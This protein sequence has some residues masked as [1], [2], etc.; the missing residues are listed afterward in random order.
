MVNVIDKNGG[1]LNPCTEAK[2]RHLLN[3]KK[4]EIVERVPF[5]I[6]LNFAVNNSIVTPDPEMTAPASGNEK[7]Q[8]TESAETVETVVF[9]G[10]T[11]TVPKFFKGDPEGFLYQ[12]RNIRKHY[13]GRKAS[14]RPAK[15]L[16]EGA[17]SHFWSRFIRGMKFRVGKTVELGRIPEKGEI[18]NKYGELYSNYPWNE[19]CAGKPLKW[20]VLDVNRRDKTVLLLSDSIIG[21]EYINGKWKR[22]LEGVEN[23]FFYRWSESDICMYL[24]SDFMRDFSL[25]ELPLANVMHKTEPGWF[26]ETEPAEY[27]DEKIF[28]LSREEVE[29]YLPKQKDKVAF[30]HPDGFGS[31]EQRQMYKKK[32]VKYGY[33]YGDN[34]ALRSPGNYYDVSLVTGPGTHNFSGPTYVDEE[35]VVT[36]IENSVVT[37]RPYGIRPAMW[38]R[39][40]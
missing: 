19:G 7:E 34:W 9:E 31:G 10:E 6:R 24:N 3:D 18:P 40:V 28:L 32:Q 22:R 14:V 27:S 21:C 39:I 4:A 35:G 11:L 29:K 2:A 17:E 20:R 26:Y 8:Q 13:S 1:K 38:L 36:A 5:T 12:L 30:Y 25:E 16:E 33:Y 15:A 37:S 23:E